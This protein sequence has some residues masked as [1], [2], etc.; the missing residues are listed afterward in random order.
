M[1]KIHDYDHSCLGTV[2]QNCTLSHKLSVKCDQVVI[3]VTKVLILRDKNVILAKSFV[4]LWVEIVIRL[5]YFW[6]PWNKSVIHL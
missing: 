6:T 2:G 4:E 1:R 3:I 5:K